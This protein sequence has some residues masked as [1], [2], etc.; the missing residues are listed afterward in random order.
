MATLSNY[1]EDSDIVSR[2][3]CMRAGR[4][5]KGKSGGTAEKG[6]SGGEGEANS[7]R[8]HAAVELVDDRA[9]RLRESG[10]AADADAGAE[11]T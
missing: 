11:R 2:L 4:S 1:K 5:E 9:G 10:G 6:K 7:A 3:R 8:A